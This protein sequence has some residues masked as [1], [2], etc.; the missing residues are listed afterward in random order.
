M[1]IIFLGLFIRIGV[2]LWNTF[3][4]PT[5]GAEGDALTFHILA[6]AYSEDLV[7][8]KFRYGWIY[9]FALGV[10]YFLTTDSLLIGCLLSCFVWFISAI[11]F[12][13]SLSLLKV[14]PIYRNTAL[15]LYVLL[16]SSILFTSVT[17]REVY[18]LLFVTLGV[19]SALRIYLNNDL[20]YWFLLIFSIGGM[21]IFHVGLVAYGLFFLVLVFYFQTNRRKGISLESLLFYLPFIGLITYYS[22]ISYVSLSDTGGTRIE[23]DQGLAAA[24]QTYQF[25]HN[26]ARA[27]YTYKPEVDGFLGL[28]LFIPVSL[29]QY[30]FEPMPWRASTLFD[31]A[32]LS[33][34]ILRGFLIY[35]AVSNFIRLE[36]FEKK[37]SLLLI[38]SYFAQ[39][40]LWA[41]GTVNWGSAARH[42]IPSLG[43]LIVAA[44]LHSSN[45][46]PSYRRRT[47]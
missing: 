21:G 42:H 29:F 33:E 8:E 39:E 12:D 40:L 31:F 24:V 26:E 4:G 2:A 23:F 16:P 17:L 25:G 9:S 10:I 22:I 43:V 30:L 37:L 14:E 35:L 27:M 15:L 32:L 18:E 38:L 44:F 11:I 19:Y 45:I 3:S 46:H 36:G 1:R 28:I 20:R 13:K 5:L 47:N 41:M 34:N 6:V 7:W